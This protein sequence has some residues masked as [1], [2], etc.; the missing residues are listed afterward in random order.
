MATSITWIAKPDGVHFVSNDE[1]IH[2]A[3]ATLADNG[4]WSIKFHCARP[5]GLDETIGDIPYESLQYWALAMACYHNEEYP[6]C[7]SA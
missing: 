6:K 7:V 4:L 3:T 1:K 5:Q 2:Y